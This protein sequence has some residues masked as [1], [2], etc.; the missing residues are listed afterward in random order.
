MFDEEGRKIDLD[1][2]RARN[3]E[4]LSVEEMK[5]YIAWLEGEITRTQQAMEQ[6]DGSRAAA[7]SFFK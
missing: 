6:K 7:E 1:T 5:S 3:L 4:A 2:P